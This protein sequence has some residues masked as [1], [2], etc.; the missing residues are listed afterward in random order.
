MSK[1]YAYYLYR[2][3]SGA[4][5]YRRYALCNTEP[6]DIELHAVRPVSLFNGRHNFQAFCASGGSS[7]TFERTVLN[8]SLKES[9]SMLRLDIEANGFLYNMVRIIMGTL[10]EVGRKRIPADEIAGYY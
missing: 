9:G 8:C 5:F 4:A 6:L 2:Q 7:K 10:L 1:R 3:K